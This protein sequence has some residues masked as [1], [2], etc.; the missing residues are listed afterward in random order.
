MP[1]YGYECNSCKHNFEV[2]QSMKDEPVKEC[3]ECGKSVRR[4]I[5]GGNGIIFKG[6][7]FY[8]TDKGSGSKLK[9]DTSACQSCPMSGERS[10][11]GAVCPKAA[12]G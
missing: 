2:F 7:G 11:D 10:S 3:P 9:G 4:L 6:N 5:N 8:V 12:N 1:T